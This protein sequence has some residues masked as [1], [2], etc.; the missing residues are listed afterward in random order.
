MVSAPKD[1]FEW[2][3]VF[4][5][6]GIWIITFAGSF[7]TTRIYTPSISVII[8]DT[9]WLRL[10]YGLFVGALIISRTALVYNSTFFHLEGYAPDGFWNW[11]APRIA[12]AS[13]GLQLVSFTLVMAFSVVLDP[14]YHYVAALG[15]VVFGITCEAIL[16]GRRY[17]SGKV[18]PESLLANFVC[19][20]GTYISLLV[21]GIITRANTYNELRSTMALA[22][23]IGYYLVAYII[24]FRSEDLRIHYQQSSVQ[25][26]SGV[27]GGVDE[28]EN[29]HLI[30]SQFLKEAVRLRR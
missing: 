10:V 21:F 7:A 11:W 3:T 28:E 12:F 20:A 8:D 9:P 30:T 27:C 15:T 1:S 25:V 16:L 4:A 14:T 23:W 2:I 22:E 26:V 5:L 24:R 18:S 13:G 19:W 6:V 17:L 29:T